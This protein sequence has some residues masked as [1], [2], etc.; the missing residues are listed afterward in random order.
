MEWTFVD[1]IDAKLK[2]SRTSGPAV[3]IVNHQSSIDVLALLCQL[4]PI[5][6]GQCTVIAKKSLLYTGPFG[7]MAYMSGVTFIDRHKN[8]QARQAM[9]ETAV[10]CKEDNLK[11]VNVQ[12]VF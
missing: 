5:M 1:P 9:E 4:W 11:L 12:D 8:I 2:L 6:D 3:V 7:F 10:K